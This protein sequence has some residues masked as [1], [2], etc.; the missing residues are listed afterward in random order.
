[1]NK[2]FIKYKPLIIGIFLILI[3]FLCRWYSN[4]FSLSFVLGPLIFCVIIIFSY[5][6]TLF[7]LVNSLNEFIKTRNNVYVMT[8]VLLLFFSILYVFFPFDEEKAK[9][10]F[11]NNHNKYTEVINKIE[12]D[13]LENI[14]TDGYVELDEKYKKLSMTKNIKV[15][16]INDEFTVCFWFY[17]GLMIGD[18][19]SMLV[20]S[21]DGIKTI[22]DD[23]YFYDIVYLKEIENNWYFVETKF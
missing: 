8:F 17:K 16:K 19:S 6:G 1:M 3:L 15:N 21:S 2:L 5:L 4:Y 7:L 12:S 20:Y 14:N 9:F 13:Q 22:A 11:K 23:N 18:G 10:D